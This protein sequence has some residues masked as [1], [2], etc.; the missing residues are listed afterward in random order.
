MENSEFPGG[1]LLQM[2]EQFAG[3]EAVTQ[4]TTD[5]W[6]DERLAQRAIKDMP[7]LLEERGIKTPDGLDVLPWG[8]GPTIGMP[9]PDW[10]PFEIRLTR[11]RTVWIRDEDGKLKAETFCMGIQIVPNKIPGGPRG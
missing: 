2:A 1:E 9:G 10:Q 6:R 8:P 11:C 7:G 5:I 3:D 4:L